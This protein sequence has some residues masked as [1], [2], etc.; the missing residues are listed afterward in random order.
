MGNEKSSF[1]GI[2][3]KLGKLVFTEEYINEKLPETNT[4]VEPTINNTVVTTSTHN[5][6]T[7]TYQGT[8]QQAMLDK[9]YTLVE[10]INKPGIDFLEL[11]NAAEAMGGVNETNVANAFVALKI[12]SGNTLTKS[13]IINTGESYCVELKNALD[14]DVN[15]KV[16][17][18]NKIAEQK[19][20]N[21]N[22][23]S[24]EITELNNKIVELQNNLKEKN[25]KLQNIDADF[26]PKLKEIDEKIA[27][28]KIAVE[29]VISEMK[30]VL[31]IANKNIKD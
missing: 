13:V 2:F 31:T 24:N 22:S 21:R 10:S 8:P 30:N 18:K 17:T 28:G 19:N 12:A 15:E 25:Q 9:V 29:T 16:K 23:L 27:S 14:S 11:W 4:K 6:T 26:D 5:S 20:A 7:S 1:G 3:N